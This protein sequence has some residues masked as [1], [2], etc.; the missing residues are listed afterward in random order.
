MHLPRLWTDA[1][2]ATQ[3]VNKNQVNNTTVKL[4]QNEKEEPQIGPNQSKR[5]PT[6]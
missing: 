2:V 6:V 5:G 3:N 1:P 4:G